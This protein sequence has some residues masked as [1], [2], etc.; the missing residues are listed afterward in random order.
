ML[1]DIVDFAGKIT[2]NLYNFKGGQKM[3]NKI[4]QSC[5]MPL[6]KSEEIGTNKDGGQNE[7]YCIYCYKDGEFTDK[8]SM[9]EYIEMSVPFAE[10]AGMT[11]EQMRAH[12]EKVL[13]TLKRWKCTC[14]EECASGYNPECTCTS[15]ECSCTIKK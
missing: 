3:Y 13:P 12:C 4:C 1:A 14:T 10:Q 5:S 9:A 7:D 11:Q 15:S 2:Y 6:T 8:V